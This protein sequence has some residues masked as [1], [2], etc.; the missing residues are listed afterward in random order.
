MHQGFFIAGTAGVA[1]EHQLNVL[2]HNLANINTDGYRADRTAFSTF[3]ANQANS[4]KQM[5]AAY[6]GNGNQYVDTGKGIYKQTGND[7]DL[8]IK[9]D[10]YF[11]IALKDGSEAYSC[12]GS[13]HI[14]ADGSLLNAGNHPVLDSG[15][16]PIVLP[17]GRLTVAED[18]S[19]KVEGLPAGQLG[20]VQIIDS[21]KVQKL[22]GA[23][24]KTAASNIKPADVN[25]RVQQGM[26]EGSNVNAV[27]AMTE[28]IAITRNY[29]TMM[30][31]V[32]QYN[33]LEGQLNER[34]GI[35]RG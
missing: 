16:Q 9:G 27:L 12:A 11:K 1:A 3:F 32:E 5:P 31:I 14:G 6:L 10:G 34:V 4:N 29:Q 26:L 35:M 24:L 20:L 30:K 7:L 19:L 17:P 22:A 13:M 8:A 18:G 28:M 23:M 15:S 2:S 33:K 25:I 21:K